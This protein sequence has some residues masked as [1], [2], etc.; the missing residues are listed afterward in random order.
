VP[1]EGP[2]TRGRGRGRGRVEVV[3]AISGP[4]A[5]GPAIAEGRPTRGTLVQ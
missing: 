2:S 1:R 3:T 5:A 4:F